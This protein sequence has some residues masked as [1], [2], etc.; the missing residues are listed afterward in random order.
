MDKI[1]VISWHFSKVMAEMVTCPHTQT[2]GIRSRRGW[3]RGVLCL[4]RI[5]K[6]A[7]KPQPFT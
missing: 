7:V 1:I 2:L 6:N 4:P 5:K 3:E